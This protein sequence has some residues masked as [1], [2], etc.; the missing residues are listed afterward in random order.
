MVFSGKGEG[1]KFTCLP[2]VKAQVE[3]RLGFTPAS[4]TLNVRLTPDSI[5]IRR[6]LAKSSGIEIVPVQGYC[7]GTLFRARLENLECALIFPKVSDYPE[8]IVEIV[9]QEN[10]RKRLGLTDGRRVRIEVVT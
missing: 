10:L 5:K 4:G 6:Q 3:K 7:R 2:W 1:T 8:D 9:A